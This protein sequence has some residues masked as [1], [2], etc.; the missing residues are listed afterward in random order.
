MER[1]P[2]LQTTPPQTRG[3]PKGASGPVNSY[4]FDLAR[5]GRRV[6]HPLAA[7]ALAPLLVLLGSLAGGV[8]A[9]LLLYL[10]SYLLEGALPAD[11]LAGL[12]APGAALLLAGSFL[13][14]IVLLLLWVGLY[15]RRAPWTL[16][17]E[18]RGAPWRV[19]R[20]L[21]AGALL[22]TAALGVC[23][24]LGYAEVRPGSA[25]QLWPAAPGL[26]LILAGW[27]VQGSAEELVCRGWL[28]PV[29]G[30]RTRPWTGLLLSAL[31]FA[32]LHSLNAH[33]SAP[34]LLN[35]LL[36]GLL[37]GLYALRE[38]GLWGICALHAAWNWAQ[39]SLFGVAVSGSAF[40]PSLLRVELRGPALI[41]GG[42][43]GSEGGLA[44]TAV[45]LLACAALRW[46]P[47]NHEP[48]T[49]D[50]EPGA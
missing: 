32:A 26:L 19:A 3:R 31:L 24:A 28:L 20:G 27:L 42:A 35:L 40:G 5:R 49:A 41:T 4:L 13:P 44:V 47:T 33:L 1:P 48:R 45:L 12:S 21:L 2:P 6:T 16:G 36:F 34:A 10:L 30:L 29:L 15:E 37:A 8:V 7:L 23:A 38:G 25:G 17:L 9:L 22:Y 46:A 43:F 39:G 14:I 18:L 50:R 11:P